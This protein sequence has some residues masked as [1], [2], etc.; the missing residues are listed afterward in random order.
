M[1]GT[2]AGLANYGKTV[3]A[4]SFAIFASGRAWEQIRNSICYPNLP[5]RIV[6]THAGVTVGPD[7]GSHQA[8][9][10][11]ALMRVLPRM[12]VIVPADAIEV[13]A[14]IRFLA[15]RVDGPYYVRLGRDK[16][17]TVHGPDYRFEPG[18]GIVLREGNDVALVAC[19]ILVAPALE[20]AE[21][22]AGEGIEATVV[23]MSSIK[24]IDRALLDRL[25]KSCG[26]F[27]TCEEHSVIGGLT[28]AVAE[29]LSAGIPAPLEAV[30][31][32]DCFG[33]SGE[34]GELLEKFGLTA[35]HIVKKARAA[36]AR[37]HRAG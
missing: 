21:T 33:E 11:I 1:L 37:K 6:A 26:A 9:E 14:V 36:L 22:L 7:G 10:D 27:V 2:A 19:G 12:R 8:V 30:G 17:V 35:A 13:Q 15:G 32:E 25:S 34:P 28:G 29:T 18:R 20:A 23:N 5:V 3:F 24:P 4:S 16:A 31:M